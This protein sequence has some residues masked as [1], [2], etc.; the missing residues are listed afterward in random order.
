M[1][2]AREVGQ[3]WFE[4]ISAGDREAARALL[5]DRI[6]FYS[7]GAEAESADEIADLMTGYAVAIPHA[8]FDVT[9]W[10]EAADAAVVEGVYRGRHDGP[11]RTPQGEVPPTGRDVAVPFVTVF[12]ARDGKL[13]VH[14]A[15]W[16]NAT[17]MGQLGLM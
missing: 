1:S 5:D 7:P 6:D 16:D 4:A 10:H 11:F 9:A 14:R 13:T 15:Y 3:R 2:E 17:F 8:Q 12:E